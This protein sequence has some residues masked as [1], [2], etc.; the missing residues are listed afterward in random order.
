[1]TR[2]TRIGADFYIVDNQ[3]GVVFP[4]IIIRENPR[5]PRHLCSFKTAPSRAQVS[6]LQGLGGTGI[7]FAVGCADAPPTVN[8]VS[9][10]RGYGIR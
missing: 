2:K 8:K 5:L 7:I 10:L 3:T 1:M 4:Y 6:P 9:P